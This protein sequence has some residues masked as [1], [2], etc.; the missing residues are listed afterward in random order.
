MK[1][2]HISK[3]RPRTIEK[4]TRLT[5][6]MQLSEQEHQ[7]IGMVRQKK[8]AG[9]TIEI[10]WEDGAWEIRIS[11]GRKYARGIGKTF[12]LAWD[13]VAPSWA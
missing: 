4:L 9:S 2:P 8:T 6:K 3:R 11:S 13:N 7:L 1:R 12:D 10:E 5:A